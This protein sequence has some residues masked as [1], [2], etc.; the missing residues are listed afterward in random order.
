MSNGAEKNSLQYSGAMGDEHHHGA[1]GHNA[2]ALPAHTYVHNTAPQLRVIGNPG[3]LGLFSFASTTLILS[4]INVSARGVNIPN[5]VL[6]MAFFVGGLAQ[7]AAGMWEFAT[8]N[9]FGATA[10]TSYGGFWLAYAA[11]LTPAFAIAP[12][13][14]NAPGEFPNVLG[15]FL[16]AWFI[17]TFLFFLGTLRTNIALIA[18]FGFLDITFLLLMVGE[19][20]ENASVHKAGGVCG[21]ITAFVAYYAGAAQLITKENSLFTLPVGNLRRNKD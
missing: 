4:L 12:A 14:A 8:G 10:F 16:A 21:I 17:V 15:F 20:T 6:G 13:Y 7:F 19:L 11:Y 18:L 2:S 3:P 1:G 9:T 5:G